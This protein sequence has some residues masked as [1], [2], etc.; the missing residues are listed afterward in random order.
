MGGA[1]MRTVQERLGHAHVSTTLALYAH[2]VPGRDRQ[3]AEAFEG[4]AA[5]L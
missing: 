3:A 1:D 2:V 4:V 5:R